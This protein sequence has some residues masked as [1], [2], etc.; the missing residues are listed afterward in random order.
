M[1]SQGHRVSLHNNFVST[2]DSPRKMLHDHLA[3]S[4]KGH[5]D[6]L[7]DKH[8]QTHAADMGGLA[9]MGTVNALHICTR[10]ASLARYYEDAQGG[11]P[12]RRQRK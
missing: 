7:R 12:V 6:V 10:M 8:M 9:G 1:D 2:I 5:S 11:L 4:L 3:T